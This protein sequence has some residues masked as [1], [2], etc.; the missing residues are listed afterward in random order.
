MRSKFKYIES[1]LRPSHKWPAHIA[2]Y[3]KNGTAKDN[4]LYKY[5]QRQQ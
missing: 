1:L 3:V 5:I 2:I 4:T